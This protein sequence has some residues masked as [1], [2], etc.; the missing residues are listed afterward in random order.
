VLGDEPHLHLVTAENV[1]HEEVVRAVVSVL[2]RLPDGV[3]DLLDDDLVRL[4]QARQHGRDFLHAVGWARDGRDLRDVPR[5]GHG[6]PPKRLDPLRYQVDDLQ[7]FFGVLVQ[8]QMEL[9]E[10]RAADQPVV[11]LVQVVQDHRVGQDLIEE[12]GALRPSLVAEG[13]RKQAHLPESLD[14][15]S[16]LME[17]RLTAFLAGLPIPQE[18]VRVSNLRH[19]FLLSAPLAR[20]L[21]PPGAC[22]AE[23]TKPKA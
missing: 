18:W 15:F 22:C 11:L 2:G 1:A 6:R 14:L 8:Q 3:T 7:L 10:G 16:A 21:R 17:E 19:G 20:A 12:L 23:S 13:D 4:E 9:E 5:V